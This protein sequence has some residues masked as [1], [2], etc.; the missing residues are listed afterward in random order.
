MKSNNFY[1]EQGWFCFYN[2]GSKLDNPYERNDKRF[3]SWLA[4]YKA[5]KVEHEDSKKP[6]ALIH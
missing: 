4:G 2:G 5:A 3:Y 6:M 1:N